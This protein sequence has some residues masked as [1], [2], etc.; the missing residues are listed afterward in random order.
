METLVSAAEV[1]E[2]RYNVRQV[3][4]LAAVGGRCAPRAIDKARWVLY[5]DK[6]V[7]ETNKTE[8]PQ[9]GTPRTC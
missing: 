5:N 4:G 6:A 9:R 8:S 3:V 1:A 7:G 2:G